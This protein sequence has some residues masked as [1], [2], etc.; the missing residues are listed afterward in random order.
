MEILLL[1][2]IGAVAMFFIVQ[3][4]NKA[5]SFGKHPL[6]PLSR[7]AVVLNNKTGDVVEVVT[8]M[9]SAVNDQITDS[10]T[11][12]PVKKPRKPRTPKVETAVKEKAA[13]PVKVAAKKVAV[14][15]VAASRL[16]KA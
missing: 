12:A 15:K 6:D 14:K 16:K 2:I 13:K 8:S 9:P 5:D 1:I 11:Q 3:K 4:M 7:D 10:V